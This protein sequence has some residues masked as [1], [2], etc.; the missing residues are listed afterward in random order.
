[1]TLARAKAILRRL[2]RATRGDLEDLYLEVFGAHPASGVPTQRLR[3]SLQ[4]ELSEEGPPT[5]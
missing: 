4:K 2:K 5:P 1:M 3:E